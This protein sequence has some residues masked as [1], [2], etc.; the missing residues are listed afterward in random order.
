MTN[1]AFFAAVTGPHG[2]F[3]L[4]QLDKRDLCSLEAH[5][6][7]FTHDGQLPPDGDWRTWLIIAGR[8]FGKTR[9]GA[10]WVLSLVR[11]N[12]NP[13]RAGD[14]LGSLRIALVAATV[15]EARSV[16]IEGP[17][18]LLALAGENE[19]A[20]WSPSLRTLRFANGALATL[21]SGARGESLRGPEHHF[22]WCDE[23]A[24]WGQ[25]ENAW[26]N[27]QLGLRVGHHPRALVTTTP[28]KS[29]LLQRIRDAPDTVETGGAT[30]ANPHLPTAFVEAMARQYG[31]TRL[32]AQEVEGRLLDDVEGS[33][34]PVKLIERCRAPAFHIPFVSSPVE[35]PVG[36]RPHGISTGLD[37]NGNREPAFARTVIGVDP[38]AS[39]NGTCGIVVCGLDAGG[40]GYVIADCSVSGASPETWARSVAD[41]AA[42]FD[43]DRVVAEKNQGGEM[44]R[45][46][47]L[48]ASATLPVE[49]VH[50]A[51][52]K[53]ARAE[54]VAALF[55][56]GR[57]FFAGR[58]A[59]LE[60]QLGGM[61]PGGEYQG[62]STGSGG[63]S[64]DRADAMVW[65]LWALLLKPQRSEPRIRQL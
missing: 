56:N 27:L 42:R 65:A 21:Y 52:G 50:A 1:A 41:T 17:S 47:L 7:T 61:V 15:E 2:K 37:A 31:G 63:R 22:A 29:A 39:A 57:A 33:L 30:T 55:E 20:E 4:G 25:A 16:M 62:P 46:V 44:V 32:G 19:I 38:P 26:N 9:A 24:K 64:P 48:A 3:L 13:P 51:V 12:F 35:T 18:G 58:F 54:P 10:E 45:S 40:I 5:F 34:W 36:G 49:L 53:T 59:E 28:R 6:P 43:A 11:G 60:E 23:L 14:D 8:G